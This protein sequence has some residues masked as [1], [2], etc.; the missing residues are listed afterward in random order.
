LGTPVASVSFLS[1]LFFNPSLPRLPQQAGKML[2]DQKASCYINGDRE[3]L[4]ESFLRPPFLSLFWGRS[5]PLFLSFI[6]ALARAEFLKFKQRNETT[7]VP[8][9]SPFP[10]SPPFF[11]YLFSLSPPCKIGMP[12]IEAT[13]LCWHRKVSPSFFSPPPFKISLPPH[14]LLFHHDG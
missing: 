7:F 6:R 12:K 14:F 11:S 3:F 2:D 4:A 8:S 9:L 10:L 5:L 13:W 1:F